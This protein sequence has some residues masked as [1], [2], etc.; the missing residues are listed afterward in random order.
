MDD[1]GVFD[2][3]KVAALQQPCILEQPLD[4]LGTVFGQV[5]RFGLFVLLIIILGQ[6]E[7][8][9]VDPDIQLGLVVGGAGD[10]QRGARF[11]DQDRIDLVD[12]REIE[13]AMDHLLAVELH[14]VAQIIEP[15]L[16]VRRIGDVAAIG[17]AALHF[18]EV[19]DDD[20][21]GQPQE[22]ID[23]PH[24]F[25]VAAGEI[26]VDGHDMNALALQRVEIGGERRDQRLAFAR[27]HFGDLAA[28]HDDAADHL[29]VEMAHPQRA[30]CGLAH[31]RKGFGQ[32]VVERFAGFEPGAEFRRLRLQRRVIIRLHRGFKGVDLV[33]DLA[34][35]G[36]ITV[37]GRAEQ[38]LGEARKHKGFLGI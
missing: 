38:A 12:D 33:D 14:I 28:V 23:L 31:R 15:Q 35:R 3:V 6:I 17:F 7:H 37:V 32:D 19:G 2:V 21:G 27:S 30:H 25:G 24:P 22:T 8:D 13:G 20:P 29:D 4:M 1:L 11:V 18:V 36:D 26:V 10:N 5:D 16:V 34:D 9:L